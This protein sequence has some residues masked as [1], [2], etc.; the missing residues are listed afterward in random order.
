MKYRLNKGARVHS[1]PTLDSPTIIELDSGTII[2]GK[3]VDK[4]IEFKAL[5]VFGEP[6]IG[7][8]SEKLVDKVKKEVEV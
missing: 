2:E 1:Q 5:I 3:V 4:F 6:M 7:Y 8:V